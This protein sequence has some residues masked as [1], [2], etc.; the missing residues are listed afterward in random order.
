MENTAFVSEL[1]REECES[2]FAFSRLVKEEQNL[3]NYVYDATR[4]TRARA[5]SE[6]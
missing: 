6:F 2:D 1:T 5:L 4:P 3:W